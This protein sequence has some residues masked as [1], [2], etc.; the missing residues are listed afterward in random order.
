M[1]RQFLRIFRDANE[2]PRDQMQKYLRGTGVAPSEFEE[3]GWCI[4]KKKV[5]YLV[6]LREQAKVFSDKKRKLPLGD[7]DQAMLLIGASFEDSQINV[8]DMLSQ[9]QFRPHPALAPLLDW[10]ERHGASVEIRQ[11]ATRA[12][13][14]HHAWERASAEKSTAPPAQ[15]GL[16]ELTGGR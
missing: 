1:T 8:M 11:A 4:E 16:F 10:Y 3:R 15:L 6:P 13:K 12:R 5:Y 7:H 9:A 2:V 14:L